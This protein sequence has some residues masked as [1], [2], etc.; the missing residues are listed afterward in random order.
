MQAVQTFQ[1]FFAFLV[2]CAMT[3]PGANRIYGAEYPISE[4]LDQ[5]ILITERLVSGEADEVPPAPVPPNVYQPLD[6]FSPA[7]VAEEIMRL[8]DSMGVSPLTERPG[9]RPLTLANES[10]E[11]QATPA[12]WNREE[13]RRDFRERLRGMASRPMLPQPAGVPY[14]PNPYRLNPP[15]FAVQPVPQFYMQPQA[16]QVPFRYEP[17]DESCHAPLAAPSFMEAEREGQKQIDILR[18]TAHQL[19]ETAH[20]LECSE[21]FERADQVRQLANLLRQDARRG[22]RAEEATALRAIRP[23]AV[24]EVDRP[25]RAALRSP[26]AGRSAAAESLPY[27]RNSEQAEPDCP[28]C[29]SLESNR[30]KPIG[31]KPEANVE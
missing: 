26:R 14:G 25:V 16:M 28:A 11:S 24:K 2:F 29:P 4:P 19:D 6:S 13:E 17:D 5:T 18:Q 22:H 30:S 7:F 23:A 31:E 8:R 21:Q 1:K 9:F 27:E 3:V 10:D 12:P 20:Q 15:T